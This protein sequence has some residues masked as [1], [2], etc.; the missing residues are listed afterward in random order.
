MHNLIK[1][2]NGA[3]AHALQSLL[4]EHS[5]RA[6]VVSFHDTAYDG[7]FQAQYG[8]GVIRVEEG[9]LPEARRIV[10]EWKESS[11]EVLPW[12]DNASEQEVDDLIFRDSRD[13]KPSEKT[14]Q[15]GLN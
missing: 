8:W 1:P 15:L 6:E 4:L 2:E 12:S 10:R 9:D 11:P 3:E 13:L 5:I 14:S 7:L